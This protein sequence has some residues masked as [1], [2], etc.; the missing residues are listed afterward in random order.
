MFERWFT[1]WREA[2]ADL[3]S[4]E[5]AL[6]L[7]A[8]ADRIAESL[9]LAIKFRPG[10]KPLA[11]PA[12][13]PPARSYKP[14]RSTPVFDQDSLPGALRR[15]HRPKAG[16]WDVIRVPVGELPLPVLPPPEV[17]RPPPPRPAT[18]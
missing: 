11:A 16:P 17:G 13:K 5:A 8:K 14:Y 1:L 6:Q 15:G 9:Q 7:Q 3:L 12:S 10:Q 18:H 2:T 4:P